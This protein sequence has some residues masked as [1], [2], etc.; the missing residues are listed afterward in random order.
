VD[1]LGDDEKTSADAWDDEQTAFI[2]KLSVFARARVGTV[3]RDKLRLDTLLGVGGMAAVYAATHR[4]G[5]RVAVKMLHEEVAT[6]PDVRARFLREGYVAN[7]VGHDGVVKIIDDD[8]A[9]D[10]SPFLVMELLDGETLEDRRLRFGGKLPEDDVLSAADQLLDVLIAAHARG[11]CHRDCKPENVF[12]TRAGQIKV[13]DFGIARLREVSRSSTATR[14]GMSMGTPAFMAPEQARGLWD[15][16]DG[17]TDLWAVGATMFNLLTGQLIHE[18]RTPNEVLLAAMTKPAPA[19]ATVLPGTGRTVAHAVDRALAFEK[20]N[21]W[22]DAKRMQEAV[23]HAYHDRHGAP[24]STAPRLLVPETVPNRTLPSVAALSN[25]LAPRLPTTGQPVF[26]S[27]AS[28][29][30]P[31][32]RVPRALLLALGAAGAAVGVVAT[33]VLVVSSRT[34]STGTAATA[35]RAV[36][37]PPPIASVGATPAPEPAPPVPPTI[38]V[39]ALPVATPAAEAPSPTGSVTP[40]PGA[41]PQPQAPAIPIPANAYGSP[42]VA[43]SAVPRPGTAPQPQAPTIPIAPNP[44]GAPSAS[45]GNCQPPF[46]VD[47]TNGKKKWKVECL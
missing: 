25:P 22:P 41:A 40:R 12:L 27:N 17:R 7:A 19:L 44:F 1:T 21:R 2:D 18:G 29:G 46:V 47:P 24:L 10:G 26:Q 34:A 28:A 33:G 16:V 38:A 6:N 9:A 4:N 32:T 8:T 39:T 36:E 5:S 14:T 37:G 11:V 31:R 13:L 42:S 45:K 30:W 15:D 23:R 3:L 43:V 35:A 20:E